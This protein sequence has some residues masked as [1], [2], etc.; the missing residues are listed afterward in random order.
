MRMPLGL[1][2]FLKILLSPYLH[3][4]YRILGVND[5]ISGVTK[6]Q[7]AK[8][9]IFVNGRAGIAF[10]YHDKSPF[11]IDGSKLL[12][13]RLPVKQN[14]PEAECTPINLGYFPVNGSGELNH[15]F[16]EVSSTSTWCWQQGCM[17]QWD[18]MASNQR[19]FYNDLV[20]GGYGSKLFNIET[21]MIE[22]ENSFPIYSISGD[23]SKALSLN[24]S[25]LGRLRP[26]YGYSLIKDP[27]FSDPAPAEDGLFLHDLTRGHG[28]LVV[29]LK[30]L[31][32]RTPQIHN[33][34]HYINH[35]SFSP[36]G[37]WITFFHIW[38]FRDTGKRGIILYGYNRN[39]EELF[40]IEN[41]RLPSH[42]CWQNEHT[43]MV[44]NMDM[45]GNWRY[46]LY[47]LPEGQRT[48]IMLNLNQDGHP[49]FKP[50]S[51]KIFVTDTYPDRQRNQHLIVA[52]LE[53]GELT[54]IATVY[55]PYTFRG[56]VRCDLHPRWDRKGK[57]IS[58]DTAR[59]G[60]RE[61]WVVKV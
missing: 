5:Q 9:Q 17:L 10:G 41:D 36:S 46:S 48:D 53:T 51:D 13:M 42:F 43:M 3:H 11:S 27:H 23:G 19:I 37:N 28:K 30:N 16:V 24:F 61:Q 59:S 56:M 45:E 20:N 25:R 52:D 32:D 33:A 26:G 47:S 55:S 50:G 29:S 14:D 22:Q 8:P 40:V 2:R 44:T 6:E 18:P 38:R 7:Y 31:A 54:K 39:L 58:F 60:Q 15:K 1:K 21:Q 57:Y 12:A 49:M 35:L 4:I 34:E